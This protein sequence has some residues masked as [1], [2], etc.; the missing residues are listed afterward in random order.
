MPS[1]ARLKRRLAQMLKARNLEGA[2]GALTQLA[3]KEPRDPSWPLRA[4][5]IMHAT[6]DFEGEVAALRRALELQVDQGLVLDA[7]ATCKALLALRADDPRTLETLELLHLNGPARDAP[8][9]A[10]PVEDD[11][12]LESL[13]LTD[14]VPGALAVSLGDAGPGD[15]SQI[16]IDDA[17]E[18]AGSPKRGP[19]ADPP[20]RQPG[21]PGAALRAALASTPIFGELDA[22][23][24]QTLI[25]HARLV[26]L[27]AGE[28]LFREG[29]A[30]DALYVVVD[31]AVVPIAE[32][33]R[34]QRL[35]V[36]ERGAFFGEIGLVTG[37]PRNATI[38][39][40]VDT[41]LLAIDRRLV[42]HLIAQAPSVAKTILRFLRA[43]M[44][45]RQVRTSPVFAALAQAE[46]DAV[47][48]Q[49]RLLEVKDGARIVEQHA[50]AEGLF[51][52]LAGS[53]ACIDAD[54]DKEVG[55]LGIGDV[56]G[57]LSTL[58]GRPETL[59]SFPTRR[60]SDHRK[61]VV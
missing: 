5:R 39:A 11:E 25:H 38:E 53:L 12:P 14:V 49:F 1:V 28:V 56:F 30:A 3:R 6:S 52:V 46:R 48:R 47:A 59:H 4:A 40:L 61:S 36:L 29:D 50:S 7:I 21:S 57:G 35:A 44:L 13:L 23:S 42:R 17:Q 31:G 9:A 45:D 18:T 19:S 58:E 24:L 34:R 43:R 26:V 41:R 20:P 8:A 33:A 10:D 16:E 32:G 22:G 55:R 37:Q 15:A 54:R 2:L 27:D 51:V 60:S